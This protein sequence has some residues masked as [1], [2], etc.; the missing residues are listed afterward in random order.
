MPKR[1]LIIGG[2]I[3][4]L[5]S[6]Y[7]AVR[8]GCNVTILEENS[9]ERDM[10]SL[11]NAGMVVPSHF[12]P[13]AT[14]ANVRYGLRNVLNPESPFY[15]RPQLDRE[16]IDWGVK[17]MRAANPE[18]I[19]KG[20]LVLRDMG[21]AS[22]ALY[23]EL[24][25]LFDFGLVQKGLLMLCNTEHGLHH[26]AEFATHASKLGV[27][28]RTLNADQTRALDPGVSLNVVGSVHFPQDCH[29]SPRRLIDGLTNWLE[30]NGADIRYGR[31]VTDWK[32]SNGAVSG[33]ESIATASIGLR[34][35]RGFKP[36]ANPLHAQTHEADAYV[37]CG[38]VSSPEQAR[39]LGVH[40]PLQGGKG[41]SL[42]LPKPRQAAQVCSILVEARAAVTPIGDTLRVGGT[43]EFGGDPR[44]PNP[45]RVRGIIKSFVKY[46]NAFAPQDFDGI[47]PW[48]G[49]R[50]VSPD[51]LPYVGRLPGHANVIAAAGHAMVGISLG[52]VTGKL[53]SELVCEQAPSLPL[54]LLRPERF[55]A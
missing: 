32:L 13:L 9:R 8:A 38:G 50:P 52:P 46:Y 44:E 36:P 23:L 33:V 47:K 54:E 19:A 25:D 35:A 34:W 45:R 55:G 37:I 41:Y 29:L 17:F 31:A 6:A 3:I 28:A 26:E 12:V 48:S 22:R 49:L 7:Y 21:V 30:H 15:I 11:G 18:Q 24:A 27:T 42:T 20:E 4:G 5:C 39:Q 43:M 40:M 51:G 14:P 10:A 16:L 53:V 1:V 2:G